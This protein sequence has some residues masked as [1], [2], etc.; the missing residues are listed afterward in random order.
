MATMSTFLRSAKGGSLP[1]DPRPNVAEP[2]SGGLAKLA[3]LV[4][5]N[6][7]R[8][9][10]RGAQSGSYGRISLPDG[11]AIRIDS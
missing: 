4:E 7:A 10:E 5:A 2:G 11:S 3:A 9:T 1:P 8:R 6:T